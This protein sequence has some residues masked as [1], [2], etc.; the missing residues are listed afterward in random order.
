MLG[1]LAD[2]TRS[3]STLVAENALLRQQLI[4]LRRH[5][6]RPVF[7]KGDR[8]ILV[9]LARMARTWKQALFIVQ[10]ETLLLWHRQ[11]FNLYWKYTSR[12]AT[13]KP[14][15]ASET[16]TLIHEA[17]AHD[18]SKGTELGGL[19]AQSCGSYLGLRRTSQ[20]LT[21]CSVH[22]ARTSRIEILKTPYHA[23]RANAI[24]ERFLGSIRRE[25]LD[26]MFILYE[27]QLHRVLSSTPISS[28]SIEQ[29][30]IK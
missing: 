29:D 27:K 14:K 6:K 13:P 16:V 8:I 24:C 15:V 19:P 18:S 21:C 2:L 7:V 22:F 12:A 4:I 3:K 30:H 10:P 5:V 1:S 26:H 23:P 11:G 20:S 28:T 25:C 9:L 17:V